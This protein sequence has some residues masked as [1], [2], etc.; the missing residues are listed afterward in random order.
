MGIDDDKQRGAGRTRGAERLASTLGW[1]GIGLGITEVAV[2]GRF[3]R[4]IGLSDG[5]DSRA[6]LRLAGLRE[7]ASGV[8]AQTQRK[9]AGWLW[10]RVAGDLMD[11]AF[12]RSAVGS[13]Q[14]QR[15]GRVNAATAAVAGVTALDLLSS[16]QLTRSSTPTSRRVRKDRSLPV[17]ETITVRRP[18]EEVYR[19]WRDLENLPRFMRHLEAVQVTGERR[20]HWKAEAP[21]GRTVEW[22]AEIVEDR[23]NEL[24][25][26]RSLEGADVRNSGRVRFRPAPG[27]QGTEVQV[28]LRYDPPGGTPGKTVA[29]LFGKEPGQEVHGDLRRLKQVLEAGEVIISDATIEGSRLPQRPAQPPESARQYATAPR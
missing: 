1:L 17:K 2:P 27:G 15:R 10:L 23:P 3:A 7:L 16:V 14:A 6:L 13:G 22:D 8:G 25:A 11:L 26:W 4:F 5:G 18:P 9:P 21:A 29:T 19:F 24:I 28:E 20:S 12:L